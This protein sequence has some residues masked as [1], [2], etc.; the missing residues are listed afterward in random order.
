MIATNGKLYDVC[1]DCGRIVRINKPL[2]GSWHLCS[3]EEERVKYKAEIRERVALNAR[4]LATVN[5]RRQLTS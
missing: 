3:T 4:R 1:G 2:L 5:N